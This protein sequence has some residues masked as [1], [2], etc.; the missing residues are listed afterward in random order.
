[1]KEQDNKYKWYVLTLVVLTNMFTV[2][3]PSMGM[4]VLSDEISRDLNLNLVQVGIVWG[5]GALLGVAASLLGGA[6][7]DKFGAKRVLVVSVF[8]AGLFGLLR[9]FAF[10]FISMTGIVILLGA[11]IPFVTTNGIKTA[12]SWFPSHQ[13]GLANGLISMGMAL[14]F[15]IG[16]QFSATT[17]SPLLGGWRNV[18][19]LYGLI[20]ALFS[21]PWF[22]TRTP[23]EAASTG[24][25]R[26]MRKTLQHVASLKNVWLL[27]FTLFGVSGAIQGMLGYL[28][29]YLRGLGWPPAYADGALS[30]FHTISMVCVMPI[31][32]WSDRLGSRKGLLLI[33]SLF[34]A[35]GSGL[36]GF[37]GGGLI[38]AAVLLSGFVRDAFMAIFM[39]MVFET[40]G[41]D[42]D[43][44]GTALG[45]VMAISGMGT[46]LAPPI[47][48]SLA[49]LWP[50]A[51]F[52]FW[53]A[54]AVL[55]MI[56]LSTVKQA[57]ALPAAELA[58]NI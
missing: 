2:A 1:M 41:V 4:A 13:L 53:S 38:W 18:L 51:P 52:L 26:L 48:N 43:C 25:P 34:V 49:A 54:L 16:A 57:Q 31:A 42:S 10:D 44:A 35:L 21:I 3:I 7:G 9:G 46:V 30:A 12:G 40:E 15:L 36:L 32:L 39:T 55:G 23:F 28:P 56:C 19:L 50:G 47:G 14:G 5:M 58:V 20:G 45:F 29:L 6:I 8:L 11:A 27:G 24:S 37:V 33:G 17:F 22:F